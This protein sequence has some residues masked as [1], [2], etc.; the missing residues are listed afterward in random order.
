MKM[1]FLSLFF[2]I[3]LL[4][5]NSVY[6]KSRGDEWAVRRTKVHWQSGVG[7]GTVAFPRLCIR[8]YQPAVLAT[9]KPRQH[10]MIKIFF[11]VPAHCGIPHTD[12]IPQVITEHLL[13]RVGIAGREC[14][15]E[16]VN[17]CRVRLG[18]FLPGTLLWQVR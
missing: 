7:N 17:P 1:F 8:L 13:D 9:Q 3:I 14:R 18:L 2:F 12:E 6:Y 4:V 5:G 11:H 15:A 16:A 10:P